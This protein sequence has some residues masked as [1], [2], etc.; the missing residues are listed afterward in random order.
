MQQFLSD[1]F[2]RIGFSAMQRSPSI[3]DV[4]V[5]QLALEGVSKVEKADTSE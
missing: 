2:Q 5:T 4:Y 3:P 1:D